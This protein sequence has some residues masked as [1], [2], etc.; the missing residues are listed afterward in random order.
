MHGQIQQQHQ[1]KTKK[2]KT[3][4]QNKKDPNPAKAPQGNKLRELK[5]LV[6]MALDGAE[7]DR[8]AESWKAPFHKS[9]ICDTQKLKG[10][11]ADFEDTDAGRLLSGLDMHDEINFY[12]TLSYVGKWCQAVQNGITDMC[13]LYEKVQEHAAEAYA[14][15]RIRGSVQ[16]ALHSMKKNPRAKR[17]VESVWNGGSKNNLDF[18]K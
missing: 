1:Q 18:E 8:N 17:S 10:E 11:K 4:P 13:A 3:N 14:F 15:E 12:A 6:E 16:K 9:I 2:T 5:A 7:R